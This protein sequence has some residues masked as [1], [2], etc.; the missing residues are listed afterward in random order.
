MLVQVIRAPGDIVYPK[1]LVN[2]LCSTNDVGIA[3]GKN[4]IYSEG[5]DKRVYTI[6]VYS[7]DLLEINSIVHI[8]DSSLGE[9][10]FA[11]LISVFLTGTLSEDSVQ[12]LEQSIVIERSTS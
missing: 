8:D 4:F 3:F 2:P 10:F 7:T 6:D 5:V 1:V 11:R 12:M 9:S